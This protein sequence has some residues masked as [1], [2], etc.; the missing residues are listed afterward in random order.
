MN[1]SLEKSDNK[2]LN[3][4]ISS[5]QYLAH[6]A[7]DAKLNDV[8]L[9]I[10]GT[11]ADLDQWTSDSINDRNV[12]YEKI[13]DSDLHKITSLIYKFSATCNFNIDHFFKAV[14]TYHA[15]SKKVNQ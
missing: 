6:E 1:N 11:I 2:T 12:Y 10:S 7:K 4:I 14:E 13:L 3:N 9:I 5:L 8:Y 15:C